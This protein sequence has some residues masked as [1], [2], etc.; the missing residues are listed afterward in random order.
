VSFTDTIPLTTTNWTDAVT[1]S[2]FD[3]DLGDLLS[4]DFELEAFTSGAAMFESLDAS[5]ATVTLNF[6]VSIALQRPDMS[7]LLTS[8]PSVQTIDNATAYDG[9]TDFAGTSGFSYPNLTAN[10]METTTSP[11]PMSDLAL[12][13]GPAGNPGTIDLPVVAMG[14][15]SGSGAGNLILQFMSMAGANVTVTYNF[16]PDCNM[17]GIP[18]NEDISNGTSEDCN[19]NGIPDECEEDCDDDGIPDDC[20]PDCNNNGIPDDCDDTPC[21]ECKDINRRRPGSLLLYPEFDSRPGDLTILT[22]TNTNCDFTGNPFTENVRVEFVFIDR[23]DCSE[24]NTTFTMTPCDTL[25]MLV[26]AANPNQE[27]GYVYAFAKSVTTGEP[28]VYNDLIGQSLIINGLASFEYAT[29]AVSFEGIGDGMIT[30]L[31][32]D[33]IRDLDGI[34]YDEAPDEILI[35]R[36]LGQ[37]YSPNMGGQKGRASSVGAGAGPRATHSE[38]ILVNLSGG[39]AFTTTLDFLIYND[40][41]EVFSSEYTFDCW[42]KPYLLDISG[43]FANEF[44]K[45]GTNHDPDEILGASYLEAGWFKMNGAIAQSTQVVLTDP[46]FYAVLVE[47]I[48]PYAAA[49]LPFELCSQNNGDLLPRSLLGDN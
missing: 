28:I 7:V 31:D 24:F 1:V 30:D 16:A 2:K 29:N 3:P 9:I 23:E 22:I 26:S 27:Q 38:L 45:T 8:S 21:D 34:E 37:N 42:D 14:N 41:E 40:N 47:R 44:L 43:L 25:T 32:D 6:S 49:D 19:N 20:E 33:G 36:F 48:G 35:P 46:A 11:P 10:Q 18:D 17:N 4:V 15:S 39:A 13:T 12:F 5:P